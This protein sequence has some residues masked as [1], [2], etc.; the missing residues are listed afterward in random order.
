MCPCFRHHPSLL[1]QRWAALVGVAF[2]VAGCGPPNAQQ[3]LKQ[4]FVDNPRAKA[5]EVV[6]FAGTVT[7]D[8]APPSKAGTVLLVILNDPKNPQ[9]PTQKPKLMTGCTPDGHFAFTTYEA[10]DGVESGSYVVTFVQLK[11]LAAPFGKSKRAGMGPP[12]ELKN[13]YNDPDKNA[14]IP[15]FKLDIKKP[16]MTDARYKLVVEGKEPVTTP[17]PHA[18]TMLTGR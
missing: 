9:D 15:E 8:G 10:H 11:N 18:V 4:A 12:D 17:G 14:E 16:G 13:L 7:V 6:P 5:V 1:A 2:L 3:A